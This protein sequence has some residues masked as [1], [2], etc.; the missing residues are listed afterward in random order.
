MLR[1]TNDT[2]RRHI[3]IEVLNRLAKK[4]CR[5]I[6]ATHDTGIA[7]ELSDY[8]YRFFHSIVVNGDLKFEYHM[9]E[10]VCPDGNAVDVIAYLGYPEDIVQPIRRKIKEEEAIR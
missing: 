5:V 4:N 6:I 2:E 9:Q 3:C 10:G 7:P 1:G 8:D